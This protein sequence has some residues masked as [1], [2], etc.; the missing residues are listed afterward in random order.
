M[1]CSCTAKQRVSK[2]SR[3]HKGTSHVLL[4]L[5]ISRCTMKKSLGIGLLLGMGLTACV[6]S[7]RRAPPEAFTAS[8]S[9]GALAVVPGQGRD[10]HGYGKGTTAE[11]AQQ[12]AVR[13]CSNERCKLVQTYVTGQC[14]HLILGRRQIFWNDRLF[15]SRERKY[16][17][18]ECQRV[19]SGCRV[20]RSECL[21]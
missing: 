11:A 9:Y 10:F 13:A 16:T 15:S 2:V 21:N 18:Q 8:K 14:V 17:L 1:S 6:P 12:A 20:L 5:L 7:A 3:L 4:R 19:D